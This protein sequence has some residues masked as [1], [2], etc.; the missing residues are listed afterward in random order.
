MTLD[1]HSDLNQALQNILPD[2][3]LEAVSL[4]GCHSLQLYLIEAHY[5]LDALDSEA[6]QRVMNNPLYWMFCWA[7]GHAMAKVILANPQWVAGK[8]VLDFGSG[9]GVV[10]IACA[11]AGAKQVIASDIDPLSQQ[12]IRLNAQLN[13]CHDR[14][15]VVGDF[16]DYCQQHND[17][18][19][20]TI[21]DVLYDA[22][23]RPLIDLLL[24]NSELMLL[25][26]SRVKNFSHA[27][28]QHFKQEP[29]ETFP[30]L[31]GFDEFSTVNFYCSTSAKALLE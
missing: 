29:G 22:E 25:A 15:Q 6:Q 8:T 28:L 24:P 10:A 13:A 5:P 21:A 27:Q 9:S 26:D 31:G 2:A 17:L 3:S 16:Q 7:S 20:I 30:H 11:L 14:I 23:N 1:A 18:D 4:P 12:T 19:L